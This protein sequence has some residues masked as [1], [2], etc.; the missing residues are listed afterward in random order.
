MKRNVLLGA[1][2]LVN[3]AL[4]VGLV[5]ATSEPKSALAASLQDGAPG[6]SNNYMVVAGEIQD[7]YDA[8]YILDIATRNLYAYVYDQGARQLKLVQARDLK[9]DFRNE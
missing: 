4:L 3:V 9:R 5:S 8:V 1:L 7:Q 2:A 6:L